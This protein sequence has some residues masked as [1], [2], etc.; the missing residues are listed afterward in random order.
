M[1]GNPA[2]MDGIRL[3]SLSLPELIELIRAVADEILLRMMQDA[4]E[5]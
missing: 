2:F 1:S 5:V 3:D 4:G